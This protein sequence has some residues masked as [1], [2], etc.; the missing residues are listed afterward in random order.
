VSGIFDTAHASRRILEVRDATTAGPEDACAVLHDAKAGHEAGLL[1][2]RQG[3]TESIARWRF[4][5]GALFPA[6]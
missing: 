2:D 3:R 5:L 4:T 1:V 6:S